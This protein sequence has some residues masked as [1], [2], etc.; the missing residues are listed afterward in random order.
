MGRPGCVAGDGRTP[1]RPDRHRHRSHGHAPRL[2]AVLLAPDLPRRLQAGGQ[3]LLLR[4]R[5]AA[6]FEE[7]FDRRRQPDEIAGN[8]VSRLG[9]LETT[10]LTQLTQAD[11]PE[12]E[13]LL[14]PCWPVLHGSDNGGMKAWKLL[15]RMEDVAWNPP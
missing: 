14:E 9:L 15:G 13:E 2:V 11:T 6:V 1:P 4:P 8:V 3:H 7:A 5:F 12:L 10:G